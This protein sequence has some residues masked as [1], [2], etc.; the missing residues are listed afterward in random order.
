MHRISVKWR[1]N[2]GKLLTITK[3]DYIVGTDDRVR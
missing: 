1:I 3:I 2:D